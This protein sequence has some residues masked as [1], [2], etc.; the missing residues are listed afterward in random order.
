MATFR[1]RG[2]KWRVEVVRSGIRQ[3]A[4]FD[5]KRQ[6]EQ[7]ANEVESGLLSGKTTGKTSGD[8]TLADALERFL[9][10]VSPTHRGHKREAT[11][12]R[13]W[14]NTHPLRGRRIDRIAAHDIAA[15]RDERL[16]KVMT[17]SVR[18]EMTILRS[19]FEAARLDWGW[20]AVNPMADVRKPPNPPARTRR[21]TPDEIER[22]CDALGYMN[23]KATNLSQEVAI[24]MLLSIETAMRAGELLTICPATFD[25]FARTVHLPNTKNGSARIVPL[26]TRAIELIGQ[27]P[28]GRFTVSSASLDA[29]FRK[30]KKCCLIDDLHFHDM[31]AEALTRLAKKVDVLTL[32]RISGHKDIKML[33]VYY[34]ESAAD[35]AAR[36]G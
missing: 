16:D 2:D 11:T 23:E 4:T 28:E 7:W 5:T 21:P 13:L 31:R 10:E 27:L 19:V 26:S 36:L 8:K 24:A 35:I 25:V 9:L 14:I 6:A 17:S 32:A 29:L 3:S 30:A 1:K 22:L 34:R 20:I 33:M 12:L 15:W 18:R